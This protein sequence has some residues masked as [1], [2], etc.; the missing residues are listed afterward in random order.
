MSMNNCTTGSDFEQLCV[1]ALTGRISRKDRKRLDVWLN[2]SDENRAFFEECKKLW[3]QTNLIEP[4]EKFNTKKEWNRLSHSLNLGSDIKT[5]RTAFFPR[6]LNGL[7]HVIGQIRPAPAILIIL[8]LML[9]VLLPFFFRTTGMS[10]HITH[11]AQ[12]EY[13]RLPDGT[14]VWLN[15][16]SELK[17]RR[18]F[19]G[20]KRQVYLSGEAYFAV[21]PD[22]KPFVVVTENA[23][24]EVLGTAF[25]VWAR[26]DET[27]VVVKRG[28]VRLTAARCDTERVDLIKNQASRIVQETNP[29]KPSHVD[30]DRLIGWMEGR[31][32]FEKSPLPEILEE[33]ERYYDVHITLLDSSLTN[34]TVTATFENN[35]LHSVLTSLCLSL[36]VRFNFRSDH[37]I[38]FGHDMG[39][40]S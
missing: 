7:M 18:S 33:I 28:R 3:R 22:N 38:E 9:G 12:K 21:V 40:V 30:A 36:G 24:T 20:Q 27:R 14:G 5:K 37:E 23:Y 6:N 32:V 1:N 8:G 19:S 17:Y 13:I 2:K 29:R 26:H 10:T 34:K 4:V 16:Q 25:N 11:S 31:L 39:D 35:S 15:S